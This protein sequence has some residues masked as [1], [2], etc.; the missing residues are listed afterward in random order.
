VQLFFSQFL[1]SLDLLV[2]LHQGKRTH[3]KK[4]N[5]QKERTQTTKKEERQKQKIHPTAL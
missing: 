1:Y 4:K 5:A 2:L 3:R